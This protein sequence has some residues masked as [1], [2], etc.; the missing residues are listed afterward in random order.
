MTAPRQPAGEKGTADRVEADDGAYWVRLV[1]RQALDREGVAMEHCV[2]DGGYDTL[3]GGE[4]LVDDSI[5]SL[6]TAAGRS[7][8]TVRIWE[9][10]LD[11]A[12]GFANHG[13]G[14]GA[15]LQVR[16]LAK[17][18][19]AAG[20][21]LRVDEDTGIVL[22]HDGRSFRRD[23]LPPDVVAAREAAERAREAERAERRRRE[24][25]S[26]PG[27]GYDI[28]FAQVLA[29]PAGSTGPFV[30]MG[31]LADPSSLGIMELTASQPDPV[32][33][34]WGLPHLR[35]HGFR[36]RSGIRFEVSASAIIDAPFGIQRVLLE[37]YRA[38]IARASAARTS[39]EL[40]RVTV[41]T[42]RLRAGDCWKL[43]FA[44]GRGAYNVRDV[45]V[46]SGNDA[47]VPADRYVVE[48]GLGIVQFMDN[49]ES[50]EVRFRAGEQPVPVTIAPGLQVLSE[51]IIFEIADPKPHE[52][53]D[54]WIR[55]GF[56]GAGPMWDWT[57]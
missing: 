21:R 50:V 29:R 19:A 34:S 49:H 28:P 7:V 14:K 42:G 11:Y 26:A 57:P 35:G 8:L 32:V 27:R 36:T 9:L 25:E 39:P 44:D 48:A 56:W 13:P 10:E 43:G 51:P 12:R 47:P 45:E 31:G 55:R 16:H 6:R 40:E 1:T 41:T 24:R 37:A 18:F 23:R 38:A 52:D 2:G 20:H 53:A 54:S 33:E 5:W 3:V 22:L 15:A 30:P 4:D 46:L 17:A